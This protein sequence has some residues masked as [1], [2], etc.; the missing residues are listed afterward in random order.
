MVVMRARRALGVATVAFV[1]YGLRCALPL[2]FTVLTPSPSGSSSRVAREA[3]HMSTVFDNSRREI[4]A[5]LRQLKGS[6]ASTDLSTILRM[7]DIAQYQLA[8]EWIDEPRLDGYLL[9][10][11]GKYRNLRDKSENTVKNIKYTSKNFQQ[12]L[13]LVGYRMDHMRADKAWRDTLKAMASDLEPVATDVRSC[14]DSVKHV[15]REAKRLSA[16]IQYEKG[17]CPDCEKNSTELFT[18][19]DRIVLLSSGLGSVVA[20]LYDTLYEGVQA[21][22]QQSA[23]RMQDDFT[24]SW[25]E[26]RT[27]GTASSTIKGDSGGQLLAGVDADR[28]V[29][30]QQV[31]ERCNDFLKASTSDACSRI[32]GRRS[33]ALRQWTARSVPSKVWESLPTIPEMTRPGLQWRRLRTWLHY[34]PGKLQLRLEELYAAA[35]AQ[36]SKIAE[37]KALAS[38]PSTSNKTVQDSDSLVGAAR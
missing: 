5:T 1:L 34:L 4:V 32:P 14:A 19:L 6:A 18:A 33:R 29:P 10:L 9:R 27:L 8:M 30:F 24:D 35:K 25:E 15:I 20:E 2:S 11:A 26:W 7:V 16:Q 17:W 38:A 36:R 37:R 12:L 28:I 31:E 21:C 23:R 22:G 3:V 13:Q